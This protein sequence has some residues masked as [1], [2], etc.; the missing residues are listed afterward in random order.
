MTDKEHAVI[1]VVVDVAR[2]VVTE[3]EA[4]GRPITSLGVECCELRDALHALDAEQEN[5]MDEYNWLAMDE[6]KCLASA[7]VDNVR[8]EHIVHSPSFL[9]PGQLWERCGHP[10]ETWA[11]GTERWNGSW[12]RLVEDHSK[13]V[14]DDNLWITDR[15]PTEKDAWNGYVVVWKDDRIIP[16]CLNWS[17]D[18]TDGMAWQPVPQ[19][20]RTPPVEPKCEECEHLGVNNGTAT[21][22]CW[23]AK[24]FGAKYGM[25]G[26]DFKRK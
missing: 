12:W 24:S 26:C 16:T 14:S 11:N 1:E 3:W 5:D 21:T 19:S 9:K 22:A 2:C 23:L 6:D 18:D 13:P 17:W 8:W 20:L 7:S 15:R 10:G 4:K 25:D